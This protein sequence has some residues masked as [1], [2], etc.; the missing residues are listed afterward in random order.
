M[1]F[2]SLECFLFSLTLFAFSW[3]IDSTT[4]GKYWIQDEF[5]AFCRYTIS[6]SCAHSEKKHSQLFKV[7]W[8]FGIRFFSNSFSPHH[9][10]IRSGAIEFIK[11]LAK[12]WIRLEKNYFSLFFFITIPIYFRFPRLAE[13]LSNCTIVNMISIIWNSDFF[14]HSCIDESLLWHISSLLFFLCHISVYAAQN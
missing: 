11:K 3:Q 2:F 9:Q 6:F 8:S 12:W 14:I 1:T 4:L 10:L 7:D 5:S 13:A